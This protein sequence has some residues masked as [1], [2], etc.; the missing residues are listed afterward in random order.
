M[1]VLTVIGPLE[2]SKTASHFQVK[3]IF[4]PYEAV[5]T[6]I[7]FI[8]QPEAKDAPG[9][10]EAVKTRIQARFNGFQNYLPFMENL[11]EGVGL[12]QP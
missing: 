9:L 12:S 4:R 5:G 10:F 2:K 1:L 3:Q 8:I 6:T 11:F 7:V